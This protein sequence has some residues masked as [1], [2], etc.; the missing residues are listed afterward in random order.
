MNCTFCGGEVEGAD[1]DEF[2][3]QCKRYGIKVA[4]DAGPMHYDCMTAIHAM[5]ADNTKI[6]RI[7]EA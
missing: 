6:V 3:E 5:D 7:P 4:A 1:T 2:L